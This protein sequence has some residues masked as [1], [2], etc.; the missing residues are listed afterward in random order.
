MADHPMPKNAG[1]MSEMDLKLKEEGERILN[2]L[3]E[4]RITWC[5]D[6]VVNK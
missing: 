2:F 3:E 4:R 1:M 5:L 6:N